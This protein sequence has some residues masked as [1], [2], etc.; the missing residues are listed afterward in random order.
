MTFKDLKSDTRHIILNGEKLTKKALSRRFAESG[1]ARSDWENELLRFLEEWFSDADFVLAQTSGS[2]GEPKE[3]HLPKQIMINSASRTIRYFGLSAG[4]RLLL[5]LPCRYIAG[6]MMVVRAIV[7][8]MNLVAVDP[9]TDFEFLQ[10]EEFSLGAMV[11]IQVSKILEKTNGPQQL[12]Q[13]RHLLIGGSAISEPLEQQV[14]R[15]K[16]RNVV[17]Y[18]MTETASHIAIREL[19]GERYS[20]FYHCLPE[21]TVSTDERGCLRVHHPDFWEP[22]LTNDMA[23]LQNESTFRI[24]GRADSVII[25]GGIKYQPEAIEKKL[26]PLIAGRFAI[27][28]VADDKLGQR[29][30]LVIEGTPFDT[31]SL[32]GKMEGT[33]PAWELPAKI[34]FV[35]KFPET[36]SGKLKRPELRALLSI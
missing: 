33:L 16:N 26:E 15:L 28:S 31:S 36:A 30:V 22:I 32:R 35:E 25:S 6:K 19:S 11:P 17:T 21:I 12:E 14:R 7:G 20:A 4:D 1:N 3:I 8:Q 10:T 23:D 29:L 34:F 2:T 27:S 9:S 24:V 13:I 5:S 18:G